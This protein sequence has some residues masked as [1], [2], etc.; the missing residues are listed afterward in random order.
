MENTDI[1]LEILNSSHASDLVSLYWRVFNKKVKEEYFINKY[2]LDSAQQQ[3]STIAKE[4]DQ[5]IGFYGVM[6]QNFYSSDRKESFLLG[7]ACDFILLPEYRGKRIF[8]LLYMHSLEI[9]KNS[10]VQILFG[11][12]SEQTYK[13]SKRMGWKDGQHFSRLHF[14]IQNKWIAKIY[15]K[16]FGLE[17]L[18]KKIKLKFLPYVVDVQLDELNTY[19]NRFSVKYDEEFIDRKESDTH[20]LIE[21]EGCILWMKYNGVLSIGFLSHEQE[22]NFEHVIKRLKKVISNCGVDQII[23]HVQNDSSLYHELESH[24]NFQPSFKISSFTL[25]QNSPSFD[26]FHLNFADMDIF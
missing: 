25:G 8:D 4:N 12:Q 14:P 1:K 20:F 16:S 13:F 24:N 17:K 3:N 7:N 11:F 5:V 22:W 2:Q 21:V 9:C 19:P 18:S 6:M 26:E 23:L 15:R 10:G